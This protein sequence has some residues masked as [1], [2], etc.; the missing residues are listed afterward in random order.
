MTLKIAVLP[1]DGIGP[2]V[3]EQALNVLGLIS[4]L[5]GHDFTFEKGLVGGAAYDAYQQHLPSET[6]EICKK[7]IFFQKVSVNF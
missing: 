3:M 4:K 5:Y 1:G 2:E 6:L 7:R